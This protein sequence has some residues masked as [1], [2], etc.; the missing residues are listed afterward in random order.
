MVRRPSR[1]ARAAQWLLLLALLAVAYT[2][3]SDAADNLARRDLRFGF[4][5]LGDHANFDIPFH[6]I[7]WVDADT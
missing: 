4:G 5:F 2:I 7:S 6:L 3:F 1:R